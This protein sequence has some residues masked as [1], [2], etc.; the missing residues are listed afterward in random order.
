MEHSIHTTNKRIKQAFV[1][2]LL[3]GEEI[4]LDD[5]ESI[6]YELGASDTLEAA[7]KVLCGK[8]WLQ[9]KPSKAKLKLTENE[10]SLLKKLFPPRPKEASNNKL[11]KI[12]LR[13]WSDLATAI[14]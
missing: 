8:L 4:S 2:K 11:N 13:F 1:D 10:R 9:V 14:E 3:S 12:A 7:L 5:R 6:A